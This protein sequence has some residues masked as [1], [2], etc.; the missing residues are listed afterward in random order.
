M[1]SAERR[2]A[3]VVNNPSSLYARI[4]DYTRNF[5]AEDLVDGIV[6][7]TLDLSETSLDSPIMDREASDMTTAAKDNDLFFLIRTSLYLSDEE[8]LRP[9]MG[10]TLLIEYIIFK[11]YLQPQE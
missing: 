6:P 7:D 3:V 4:Q 8:Q 5:P 10:S 11:E 9:L 1:N 2:F